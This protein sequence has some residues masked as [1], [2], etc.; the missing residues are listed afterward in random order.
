MALKD[1]IK[2][3]I[4]LPVD[5]NTIGNNKSIYSLLRDTDYYDIYN[6]VT[7]NVIELE[8]ANQTQ[9][10]APWLAWSE[11][12]R[13]SNGWYFSEKDSNKFV[14]GYIGANE[15]DEMN[16]EFDNPIKACAHYIKKEIES[17]R[18]S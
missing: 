16:I 7:E 18:K 1:V 10:I 14:V 9:Y 4:L 13:S 17:I 5:F 6:K 3:I 15:K 11:N 8:L 2:K 12:K